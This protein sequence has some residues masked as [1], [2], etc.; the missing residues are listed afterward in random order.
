MVPLTLGKQV[1]MQDKLIERHIYLGGKL[2]ATGAIAAGVL[3]LA[4]PITIIVSPLT[5][6]F[7]LP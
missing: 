6:R 5:T 2:V 7:F 4:L 1:S 3:V